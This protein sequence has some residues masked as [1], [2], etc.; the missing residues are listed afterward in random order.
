VE[1][2][3]VRYTIR[4]RIERN[5]W[6]VAIY[7]AGIEPIERVFTGVRSRAEKLAR[8]MIDA[9]LRAPHKA[10]FKLPAAWKDTKWRGEW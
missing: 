5:E 1:Y 2:R 6:A 8:A 4:V 10:G 3:G 7:P 9:W